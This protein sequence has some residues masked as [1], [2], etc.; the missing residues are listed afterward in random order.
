MAQFLFV[1]SALFR[2]APTRRRWTIPAAVV[3]CALPAAPRAQSVDSLVAVAVLE[4]P[5]VLAA[6][7]SLEAAMERI[8]PAGALPDPV[9]VYRLDRVPATSA[10]PSRARAQRFGVT[11][12]FPFPGKQGRMRSMAVEEA[13]MARAARDRVR[14][15]TAAALRREYARY[16]AVRAQIEILEE[17]VRSLESLV[18]TIR[19]R[20]EVGR[21]S[22]P[23]LLRAQV[24]LAEARTRRAALEEAA[25]ASLARINALLD[26]APDAPIRIT[27]PDTTYHAVFPE[28]IDARVLA[29]E[30]MVRMARRAERR[31]E[32]AL[33]L[34]EMGGLPD[35]G[36][37]FEYM[38]ERGMP[39][40]WMGMVEIHLPIWRWN[41]VG[42]ARK[43]AERDRIAAA[44]TARN[45]ERD[46]VSMAR[47]VLAELLASRKEV[48]L[49]RGHVVP[50]ARVALA[51]ARVSYET[52]RADFM[53]LL[54][55]WRTLLRAELAYEDAVREFLIRRADL[56][57]AAGDERLLGGENDDSQ[58]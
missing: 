19:T 40:S 31:S 5:R 48:S 21:A 3:L 45:A 22:Q 30:P 17:D 23:D 41:K 38:A 33:R 56:Q 52:G 25:P 13:G 49:Y 26:R 11:Q 35:L 39:D 34:A 32:E 57:L 51:S 12:M 15:E 7:A 50:Q 53:D 46:A 44:E 28:S 20:Y 29:G 36:M 8:G 37:G 14:L 16:A 2:S 55:A 58:R 4:N 42:P 27:R 1:P 6:G 18:E 47:T 10:D 24:E 9:L 43:A 54:D